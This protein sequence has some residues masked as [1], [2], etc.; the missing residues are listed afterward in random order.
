VNGMGADE[1]VVNGVELFRR[2]FGDADI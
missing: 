1:I 2:G